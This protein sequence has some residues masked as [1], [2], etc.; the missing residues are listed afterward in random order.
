MSLSSVTA[1]AINRDETHPRDE[2]RFDSQRATWGKVLVSAV[3]TEVL[4]VYTATLGVAAG[5]ATSD[6]PHAYLPFRF[7]WY[8]AWVVA[9]PVVTGLLYFRRAEAVREAKAKA[10]P[11]AVL[12]R[13]PWWKGIP[14]PET[15]VATIAAVAWFTA[16]PGSPW[17]I[18][19]S[20]GAFALTSMVATA[21]GAML[22]GVIAPTLTTPTPR[23][24]QPAGEAE[25]PAAPGVPTVPA[26]AVVKDSP[27]TVPAVPAV[28]D[29]PAA[30]K[31]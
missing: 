9:T 10:N 16:M 3:P 23:V 25:S 14:R 24:P 13:V 20:G 31:S 15:A 4:A 1:L 18:A 21:V 22:A 12:L 6:N 8:A 11:G 29:S 2:L 28:K 19:L 26:E 27:T 7:A 17:Q 5:L 30:G